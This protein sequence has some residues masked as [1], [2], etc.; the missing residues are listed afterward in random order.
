MDAPK[1][2]IC[3]K[4]HWG[5]CYEPKTSGVGFVGHSSAEV[6]V[7]VPQGSVAPIP[8][9]PPEP[10]RKAAGERFDR[11]AYHRSYMKNYMKKWRAKKTATNMK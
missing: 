10:I 3:E 11:N 8:E 2:K 7:T 1:C 4:K 9:V 5:P 6:S